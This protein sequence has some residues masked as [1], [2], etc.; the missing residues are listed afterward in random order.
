M[1]LALIGHDTKGTSLH[2]ILTVFPEAPILMGDGP[3]GPQ[4]AAEDVVRQLQKCLVL[5]DGMY[6]WWM[7]RTSADIPGIP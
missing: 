7:M 6:D 4:I 5:E 1:P 2:Q 3:R